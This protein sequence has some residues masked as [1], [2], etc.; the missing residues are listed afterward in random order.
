MSRAIARTI[1]LNLSFEH[2]LRRELVEKRLDPQVFRDE[3]WEGTF[4]EYLDVVTRNPRVARN[5]FPRMPPTMLRASA[6]V[7][8]ANVCAKLRQAIFRM[9]IVGDG[10]F[11][12]MAAA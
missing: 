12:S 10:A 1:G 9:A 2:L 8:Y 5:A 7:P 4:D 3:H 6:A 11:F